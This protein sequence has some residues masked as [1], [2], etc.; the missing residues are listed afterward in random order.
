MRC[1]SCGILMYCGQC[2]LHC[3]PLRHVAFVHALVI[4]Q[5]YARDVD[6]VGAR[7]A[8]LAIVAWNGGILEHQFG[9]IQQ[10]LVLF[11]S[12]RHQG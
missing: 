9:G 6:A 3:S 5:Q 12:E 2:G 10:E 1:I 8:V 4:M 11:L 7:H